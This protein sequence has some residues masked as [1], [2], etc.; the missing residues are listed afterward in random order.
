MVRHLQARDL[1]NRDDIWERSC[2]MHVGERDRQPSQR[3]K[4]ARPARSTAIARGQLTRGCGII[5]VR[6]HSLGAMRSLC[7]PFRQLGNDFLQLRLEC[8]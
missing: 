7:L 2:S 3:Y 1:Q 5:V 8:A 4:S 6:Q